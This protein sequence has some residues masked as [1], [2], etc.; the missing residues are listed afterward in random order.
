MRRFLITFGVILVAGAVVLSMF[1]KQATSPPKPGGAQSS[2]PKQAA[3]ALQPPPQ[4]ENAAEDKRSPD[5]GTPL[6]K[7]EG[8]HAV[9]VDQA[10]PVPQPLGSLDPG[11]AKVFMEFSLAGAGL[12]KITLSD[13]WLTAGW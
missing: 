10:A 3:E 4:D 11:Q 2:A 12:R 9:E 13:F 7:I 6:P 8:L 1:L 5:A